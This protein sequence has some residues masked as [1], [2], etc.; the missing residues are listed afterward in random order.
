M[1]KVRWAAGFWMDS[2]RVMD[3]WGR[4]AKDLLSE[5]WSWSQSPGSQQGK[6]SADFEKIKQ[7]PMKG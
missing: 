6:A 4:A 2:K 1:E 3:E 5:G 7:I